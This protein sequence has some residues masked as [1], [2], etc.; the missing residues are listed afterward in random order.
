MFVQIPFRWLGSLRA[1]IYVCVVASIFLGTYISKKIGQHFLILSLISKS[2]VLSF[3]QSFS[4]HSI[5][6]QDYCRT[7]VNLIINMLFKSVLACFAA[8]QLV[9]GHGAIVKAVGDQ[10]GNGTALG[11]EYNS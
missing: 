5:P 7:V 10:G 11:S 3:F 1:S 9:A 2:T 8:S 6:P 4:A